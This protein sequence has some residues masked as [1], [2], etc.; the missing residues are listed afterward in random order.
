MAKLHSVNPKD[1]RLGDEPVITLAAEVERWNRAFSTIDPAD[2]PGA[3]ACYAKLMEKIPEQIEPAVMHGDFR[4]GNMQCSGDQIH[5]VIDWEIWSVGD[6]RVDLAWYLLMSDPARPT[7][8]GAKPGVPTLD[9][10]IA[11]YEAASG[12]KLTNMNWFAALVRY[13]QAAASA[14]IHKNARKRGDADERQAT[15]NELVP[16]LNNWA[17][18]ALA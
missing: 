15:M 16:L 17:L 12:R 6:P 3:D 9:R 7:S 11:E 10:L 5:A 18:E 8:G 1:P 4:L 2:K 14:L 13:K